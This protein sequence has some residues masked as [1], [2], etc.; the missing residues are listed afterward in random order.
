M[1]STDLAEMG[2]DLASDGFAGRETAVREVVRTARANGLSPV[3]AGILGD[4]RQPT[5]ARL[6]AYGRIAA[7]L[8]A[9]EARRPAAVASAA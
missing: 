5:V 4:P 3:L 1:S 7:A 2:W 9:I 6:R 8:G